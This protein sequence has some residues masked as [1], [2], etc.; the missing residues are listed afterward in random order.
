MGWIPRG[1]GTG[2]PITMSRLLFSWIPVRTGT[3]ILSGS[4]CKEEPATRRKCLNAGRY[5]L[6]L[7]R[8][9]LCLTGGSASQT[10]RVGG[11]K[12]DECESTGATSRLVA[13]RKTTSTVPCPD[14]SLAVARADRLLLLYQLPGCLR[15]RFRG[16]L[17]YGEIYRLRTAGGEW[18]LRSLRHSHGR[19]R[20]TPPDSAR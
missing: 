1:T 17:Q 16:Q 18:K 2:L 11:V 3:G 20:R 19:H 15:D 5:A 8:P 12:N 6:Q 9:P 7:S 13:A 10:P 4:V 14:L